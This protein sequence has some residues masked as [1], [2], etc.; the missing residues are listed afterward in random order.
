MTV[1]DPK[2][3]S[4]EKPVPVSTWTL[5]MGETY[6]WKSWKLNT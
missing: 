3:S 1:E 4:L 2:K 6:T 5:A